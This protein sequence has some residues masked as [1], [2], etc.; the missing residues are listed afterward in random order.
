LFL[1]CT[2][3]DYQILRTP[4]GDNNISHSVASWLEPRI[5]DNTTALA[6][7]LPVPQPQTCGDCAP[8]YYRTS[9]FECVPCANGTVRSGNSGE[10]CS[11]CPSGTA[12]VKILSLVHF[13]NW[14]NYESTGCNGVCG[15]SGW[16][17]RSSY[18]DS[19]VGH[20]SQV[21]LSE[22]LVDLAILF[23]RQSHGFNWMCHLN[24]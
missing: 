3:G 17:M 24:H 12:A 1:A 7:E 2:T 9:T 23:L 10:S 8:G 22:Y 6:V 15:S 20:G 21:S 11:T 16:R 4:C 13:D 14:L 19:G 18:I 5:C